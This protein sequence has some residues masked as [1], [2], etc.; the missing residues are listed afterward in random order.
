MELAWGILETSGARIKPQLCYVPPKWLCSLFTAVAGRDGH[1]YVLRWNGVAAPKE[2]LDCQ[3][4][5]PGHPEGDLDFAV[6]THQL[7]V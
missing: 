7:V 2:R 5:F 3:L 6:T 4:G 1:P